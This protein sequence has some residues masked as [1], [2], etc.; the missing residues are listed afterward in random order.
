MPKVV[1]IVCSKCGKQFDREV[2]PC[3]ECGG[4]VIKLGHFGSTM[5]WKGEK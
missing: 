5:K 3:P 2:Q 1:K 4:V